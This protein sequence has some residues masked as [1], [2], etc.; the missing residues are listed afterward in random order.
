M[1]LSLELGFYQTSLQ[2]IS[3]QPLL[4]AAHVCGQVFQTKPF[5]IHYFTAFHSRVADRIRK[6]KDLNV[7]S[8]SFG[9]I[10]PYVCEFERDLFAHFAAKRVLGLL[11]RLKKAARQRPTRRRPQNVFEQQD[12]ARFVYNNS[13][14]R[15]RKLWLDRTSRTH[16]KTNWKPLPDRP[17]Q[18][19]NL[20]QHLLRSGN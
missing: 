7:R 1:I 3:D 14:R 11:L 4:R 9:E 19:L 5:E 12:L 15:Y 2:N 10:W 20:T 18:C 6:E 17:D 13:R 16:L 8:V